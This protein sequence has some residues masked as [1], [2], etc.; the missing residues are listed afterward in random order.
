MIGWLQGEILHKQ[1]P[2][3]LLGVNGVGYELEAP[4]STFYDLPS[5][6]ERIVLFTHLA[7]REDAQALYGFRRERERDLFRTLIKVSGVGAKMALAIL[8]GMTTEEFA[9]CIQNQDKTSLIRLPGIGPRTAERLLVELRDR[10]EA[11]SL[12]GIPGE[13]RPTAAAMGSTQIGTPLG[14]AISALES[15]G[16]KAVEASRLVRSVEQPGLSSEELI[17]A[18]L[19][20]ASGKG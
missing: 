18:A 4:L 20:A 15:L 11:F 3:L 10:L 7:V 12:P 5:V 19:R 6:G 2:W 8:S 9:R 14:D 17:R 13:I 16:Y 1:P